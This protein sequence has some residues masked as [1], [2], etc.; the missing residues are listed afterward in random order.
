MDEER[1]A[2]LDAA[3]EE[4]EKLRGEAT[5]A[6]AEAER[7]GEEV[8]TAA[9]ERDAAQGELAA[10]RLAA[11]EAGEAWR[12]ERE[13]A[14]AR[15][16]ALMLRAEPALP[17]A[18]ITGDSIDAIDASVEAASSVVASVREQ[19]AASGRDARVPAGAP[20]RSAP[21]LSAMTPE[22]KIRYGLAQRA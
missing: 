4:I 20:P 22:Q 8:R 3:H 12:T 18:L 9:A 7:L 5:E 10:A 1:D 11:G 15:Y 17:E 13:S 6:L 19:L 14:V 21:D 16:R 2:V